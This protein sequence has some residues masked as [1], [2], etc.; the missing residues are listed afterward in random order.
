MIYA[1][2]LTRFHAIDN[3]SMPDAYLSFCQQYQPRVNGISITSHIIAERSRAHA[4][5]LP[6]LVYLRSPG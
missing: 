6:P 5:Q 3:D 2:P 4:H 1:L